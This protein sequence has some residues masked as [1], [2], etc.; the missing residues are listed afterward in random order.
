MY[1]SSINLVYNR[2]TLILK[3]GNEKLYPFYEKCINSLHL[4]V[5][6][7]VVVFGGSILHPNNISWHF[8]KLWCHTT[9]LTL[10][11]CSSTGAK[12]PLAHEPLSSSPLLLTL[13][14]SL[15]LFYNLITAWFEK[16]GLVQ[17]FFCTWEVIKQTLG[18]S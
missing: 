8:T 10:V 4:A 13:D 6:S 14:H 5:W 7:C 18:L 9:G 15:Q 2:L 16:Q 1:Q 3:H 11:L 12:H 17:E